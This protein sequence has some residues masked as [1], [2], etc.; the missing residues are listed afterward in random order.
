METAPVLFSFSGLSNSLLR[1]FMPAS[2]N[3]KSHPK[4]LLS[5]LQDLQVHRLS[6]EGEIEVR[7]LFQNVF[8][9]LWFIL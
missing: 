8:T 5:A 3:A 7:F 1:K 9:L 4:A 2:L 6:L